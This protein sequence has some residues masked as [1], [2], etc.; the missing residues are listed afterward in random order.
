[1]RIV[2]LCGSSQFKKEFLDVEAILTMQ[3]YVVLSLGIFLEHDNIG[4]EKDQVAVIDEVHHYKISMCDEIFVVD[5]DGYIDE[6]TKKEIEFAKKNRKQIKYLSSNI[7][8]KYLGEM[9][10]NLPTEIKK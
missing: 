2:T 10:N 1:M 7:F 5:V 8:P 3:G 4:L 9:F 6:K